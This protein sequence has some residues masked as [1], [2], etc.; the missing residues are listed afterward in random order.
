MDANKAPAKKES[1]LGID[2]TGAEFWAVPY[3][4]KKGSCRR[5]E[6]RKSRKPVPKE[7]EGMWTNAQ[8]MEGAFEQYLHRLNNKDTSKKSNKATVEKDETV[9]E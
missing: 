6:I 1:L 2:P 7:L 5:V 3:S 4:A 9:T 8:A